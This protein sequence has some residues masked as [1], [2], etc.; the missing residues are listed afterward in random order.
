ME[1]LSRALRLAA[2]PV[3][4]RIEANRLLLDMRTVTSRETPR[5]I[6]TLTRVLDEV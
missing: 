1:D 5:L 4:G 6:A 2:D 3:L